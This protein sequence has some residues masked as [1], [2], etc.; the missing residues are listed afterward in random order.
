[1]NDKELLEMAAKAGGV[2]LAYGRDVTKIHPSSVHYLT[3]PIWNPLTDDRDALR[4]AV[5]LEITV[6]HADQTAW[7]YGSFGFDFN[8]DERYGNDPCAATRRAI[9]RYAAEVGLRIK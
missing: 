8:V 4:L 6:E 7:A 1:M 2:K 9:T 3:S 5:M